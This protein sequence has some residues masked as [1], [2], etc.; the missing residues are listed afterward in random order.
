VRTLLLA[1]AVLAAF[2][3]EAAERS[4]DVTRE[5]QRLN[6]C[7]STGRKSGAC[8][9]FQKDHRQALMCGGADHPSNLQW[10]SVEAHKAKTRVDR[11]CRR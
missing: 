11:Q 1:L 4:R 8:P 7:P 6:P 3:A 2:S 10:L 9:G 5:F